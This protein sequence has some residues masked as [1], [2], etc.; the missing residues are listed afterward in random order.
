MKIDLKNL[1]G[2]INLNDLPK[3]LGKF[4]IRREMYILLAILVLIIG[5]CGYLWYGYVYKYQWDDMRKQD[6]MNTKKASATFDKKKFDRV[7]NDI[8]IRKDEYQKAVETKND[9]FK[10]K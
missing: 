2:G 7:L 1:Q 8:T 9:I 5:Y 3:K 10:L 4:V 6:Y